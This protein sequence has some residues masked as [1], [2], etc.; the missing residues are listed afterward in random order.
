MTDRYRPPE[1]PLIGSPDV[2]AVRRSIEKAVAGDFEFRPFDMIGEAAER[3]R[4]VKAVIFVGGVTMMV[5]S[6]AVQTIAALLMP[7]VDPDAGFLGGYFYELPASLAASVAGSPILAGMWWVGMRQSAGYP[8][9]VGDVFSQF[10]KIGPIVGVTL[11]STLL[12][13]VGMLLF[14]VPG[15]YLSI[16]YILAL[17]LVI[18]KGLSP[19]QALETSRKAVTHCWWRML[20]LLVLTSLIIGLSALF[21]L[22]P[23]IWTVPTMMIAWAMSY[24]NVFGIS[25]LDTD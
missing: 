12:V 3:T 25:T 10:S 1:S 16:A 19:W 2:E 11:L 15:I 23:L 7:E 9:N 4:G 6:I 24:R 17:P 22:F 5:L 14:I 8:V 13:Y 18:D 20:G 21:L